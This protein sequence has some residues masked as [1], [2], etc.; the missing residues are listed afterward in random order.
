MHTV[1]K[2]ILASFPGNQP[3]A[4][5][6]R[7][8]N[9]PSHSS[10]RL[11]FPQTTRH[12]PV[13]VWPSLKRPFAVLWPSD[14]LSISHPSLS[15]G[16]LTFPQTGLAINLHNPIRHSEYLNISQ[17][18]QLRPSLPRQLVLCR[19]IC[20]PPVF[21]QLVQCRPALLRSLRAKT[22]RD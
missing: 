12:C 10:D 15:C 8:S 2:T 16:R 21:G 3:G 14:R 9:Y 19:T 4:V 5:S 18:R 17:T 7:P 13:A 11:T 22:F 6:A 20:S 1:F